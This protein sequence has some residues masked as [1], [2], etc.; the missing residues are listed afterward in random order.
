LVSLPGRA[1]T[2]SGRTA[3]AEPALV[4]DASVLFEYLAPGPR[5]EDVAP[6]FGSNLEL[7]YWV[8]DHCLLEATSALRK[9][10]LRDPGFSKRSLATAIV[11][12][13]ELGVIPV[14]S[15][16]L[17]ERTLDLI[18]DLTS[19]DATYVVLAE[20]RGIP[21][22]TLDRGL[23]QTAEARGVPVLGPGEDTMARWLDS[24]PERR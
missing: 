15:S 11:N 8:P 18:D 4:V 22:C 19:Y 17:I 3:I 2:W 9:R 12:L 7:D 24:F 21:L 1:W 10:Y 23:A 13:L 14:P 5:L 20:A 16:V 6:L